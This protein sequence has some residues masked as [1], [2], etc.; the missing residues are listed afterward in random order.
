MLSRAPSL[1]LFPV[2]ASGRGLRRRG[3][4]GGD[5]IELSDPRAKLLS[6]LFQYYRVMLEWV[7]D[8]RIFSPPDRV[9]A[10]RLGIA[11]HGLAGIGYLDGARLV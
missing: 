4:Y 11:V 9:G 1:S 2:D 6:G 5:S 10:R 3:P 7:E 8:R